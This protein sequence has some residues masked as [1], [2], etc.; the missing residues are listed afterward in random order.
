MSCRC[1]RLV[2]FIHVTFIDETPSYDSMVI[3]NLTLRVAT[4]YAPKFAAVFAVS[5]KKHIIML[6][7]LIYQTCSDN[8]HVVV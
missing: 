6:Y 2:C 3:F 8:D 1:P 5:A 4:A 7:K